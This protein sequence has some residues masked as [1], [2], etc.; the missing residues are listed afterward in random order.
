MDEQ[1]ESSPRLQWKW[2]W[3]TLGMFVVFYVGPLWGATT[4]RGEFGD[5][6]IGGWSF[7]G[8]I[9][10]SAVAGFLSK[11]VTI[12]EPA[13]AGGLLTVLWY[14]VFQIIM[15]TKG[16]SVRLELAPLLVI[17]IAIFGLSLLGAGLGEGIQNLSK[18]KPSTDVPGNP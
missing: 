1:L 5:K 2:V 7:G 12:W 11:G 9:V 16:A 3:I 14:G 8:V 18:K 10:I 13:I 15:A 4:M 6:I 17:M